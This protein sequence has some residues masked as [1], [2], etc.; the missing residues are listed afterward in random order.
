MATSVTTHS[1]P[2]RAGAA[3]ALMDRAYRSVLTNLEFLVMATPTGSL[4]NQLCDV[5]IL[6][7]ASHRGETVSSLSQSPER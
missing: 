5:Q 6:M 1:V 7:L 4:R 2:E 3:T